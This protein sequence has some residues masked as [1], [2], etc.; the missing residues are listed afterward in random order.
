M[1][2]DIEEFQNEARKLQE[3]QRLSALHGTFESAWRKFHDSFD[4]DETK[5]WCY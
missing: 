1:I 5:Q 2:L 4:N 3:Q